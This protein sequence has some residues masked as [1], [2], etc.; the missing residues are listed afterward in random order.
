MT[1]WQNKLK[2]N[3]SRVKELTTSQQN[4]SKLRLHGSG[5]DESTS[6]I[7]TSMKRP[8]ASSSLYQSVPDELHKVILNDSI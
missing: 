3:E 1:K 7:S 5:S 8:F 6:S 4:L 2:T